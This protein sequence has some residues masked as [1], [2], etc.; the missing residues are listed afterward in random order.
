MR[1]T[2]FYIG[3]FLS[4][5]DTLHMEYCKNVRNGSV[6]PQLL[7][8]SHLYL[9]LSNPAAAFA[10]LSQRIGVYQAWTRKEQ[11]EKVK[12]ARWAVGELGDIAHMLA[13]E[14][15]PTETDDIGKSQ[16]LLGYLARSEKK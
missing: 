15:L 14:G 13:E 16:I 4:L 10:L 3:R 5:V 2:F 11:D 6:P 9:A 7:G 8:N 1:D 12:L